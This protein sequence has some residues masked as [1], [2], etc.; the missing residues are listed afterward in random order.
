MFRI[1]LWVT[2]PFRS[3]MARENAERRERQ[4]SESIKSF[5]CPNC[6]RNNSSTCRVCP[7]CERKLRISVAEALA[8]EQYTEKS[9][10][11]NP[12]VVMTEADE[13]D[14][15]IDSYLENPHPEWISTMLEFLA[16]QSDFPPTAIAGLTGFLSEAIRDN[17]DLESRWNSQITNGCP[18]LR[19][20]YASARELNTESI[21]NLEP[22][23]ANN[24]LLWGALRG[25]RNFD[26]VGKVIENLQLLGNGEGR[27]QL[28]AGV[29]AKWS[30]A[31]HA[32][33]SA[34]VRFYLQQAAQTC[35]GTM[36]QHLND[37]LNKSMQAI[38]EEARRLLTGSR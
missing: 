15:F 6:G 25:G 1:L 10:A 34:L 32:N 13:L 28:E 3:S 19:R 12:A 8:M 29:T 33:S 4:E 2:A 9:P 35:S 14:L 23:A 16:K 22:S 20:L 21:L 24:D 38:E 37:V 30:L 11:I 36:A 17:P 27:Q 7:R 26:Y 31:A 18:A 5:P